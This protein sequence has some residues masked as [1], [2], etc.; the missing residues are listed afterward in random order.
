MNDIPKKQNENRQLELL[1]AQRRFYSRAKN[2]FTLRVFLAL[3]FAIGGPIL[4]S[5][6]EGSSSY[7][8]L[9]AVVC[10]VVNILVFEKLESVCKASAA[11]IQELLDVYLFDI[12]WNEV[13]VGKKPDE[14]QIA[15]ILGS[16]SER[17]FAGLEDWYPSDVERV[18][19]GLARLLCMRSNVWWDTSLRRFY[20]AILIFVLALTGI[21]VSICAIAAHLTVAKV[22]V[23][24]VFPALPLIELAILQ[25]RS[26]IEA[27]RATSE[28][29]TNIDSEIEKWMAGT[30]SDNQIALAR[31]FQDQMWNHRS[32]CPMIFDWIN[33]IARPKHE[34]MMQ[35]SAKAKVEEFQAKRSL[36]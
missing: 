13:A 3:A 18:D 27:A 15:K 11:R 9:A 1:L 19:L 34:R 10:L 36:M 35:F 7:V 6:I 32:K 23:G 5:T 25:I 8:G 12:P 14:E 4:T 24:I 20:L 22:I 26:N 17:D 21:L 30:S 31:T 28:L 33:K 2:F 16:E 29:K